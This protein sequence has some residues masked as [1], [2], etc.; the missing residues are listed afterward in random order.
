MWP[1]VFSQDQ[2]FRT[3]PQLGIRMQAFLSHQPPSPLRLVSRKN[4]EHLAPEH[5]RTRVYASDVSRLAAE[6][7]MKE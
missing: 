3:C 7:A 1:N 2:Q 4:Q 6:R 5:F